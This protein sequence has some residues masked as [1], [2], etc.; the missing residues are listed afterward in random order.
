MGTIATFKLTIFMVY[1]RGKARNQD[2]HSA[3]YRGLKLTAS[4][5]LS[6]LDVDLY[7]LIPQA[8]RLYDTSFNQALRMLCCAT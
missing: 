3:N 7:N 8:L 5:Q 6:R 4:Y 2:G 1:L